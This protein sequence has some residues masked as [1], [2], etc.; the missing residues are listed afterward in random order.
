VDCTIV[1]SRPTVKE[2]THRLQFAWRSG[3]IWLLKRLSALLLLAD[4]RPRLPVVSA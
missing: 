4:G 1:F 2:L 3:A